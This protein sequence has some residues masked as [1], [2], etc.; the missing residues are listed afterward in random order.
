MGNFANKGVP[1]LGTRLLESGRGRMFV[2][3]WGWLRVLENAEAQRR[4]ERR[5]RMVLVRFD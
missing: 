3:H 1:K 5:V 2:P 4:G